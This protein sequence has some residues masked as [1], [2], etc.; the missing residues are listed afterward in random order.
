MVGRKKN[1]SGDRKKPL[2]CLTRAIVAGMHVRRRMP[3][4]HVQW[5]ADALDG[6]SRHSRTLEPGEPHRRDF[7]AFGM[8]M[9]YVV[10]EHDFL[11][12]APLRQGVARGSKGARGSRAPVNS[13]A[14]RRARRTRRAAPVSSAELPLD[15]YV[16]HGDLAPVRV[17]RLR[18]HRSGAG[19]ETVSVHSEASGKWRDHADHRR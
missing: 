15:V 17:R 12:R 2:T 3:T 9:L 13:A 18:P 8:T 4:R 6:E 16:L 7:R 19:G 10:H 1:Y 11:V 14:D 5:T